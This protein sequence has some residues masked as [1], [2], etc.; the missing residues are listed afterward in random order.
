MRRH[1]EGNYL[2]LLA[3]LLERERLV[4]LVAVKYQQHVATYPLAFDPLNK[5]PEPGYTKL[6]GSLVVVTYPNALLGLQIR[7]PSFVVVLCFEDK[8]G[9]NCPAHR[10]DRSDQSHPLTISLLDSNRLSTSL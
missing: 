8:V 5:V 3:K 6:V 2:V 4:A 7:E 9:R 10:V 1:T